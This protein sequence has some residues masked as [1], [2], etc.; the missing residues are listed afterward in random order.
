[1]VQGPGEDNVVLVA[2]L[3]R[4]RDAELPSCRDAA[5]KTTPR[6]RAGKGVSFRKREKVALM[7]SFRAGIELP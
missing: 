5:G 1:M 4:C 6:V 7:Y 2:E 3:P